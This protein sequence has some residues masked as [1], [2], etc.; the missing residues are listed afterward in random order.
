MLRKIYTV[1]MY[2][3][4]PL[5]VARLWWRSR[6]LPAY[7]Q[8]I[9]ER[10]AQFTSPTQSTSI[11]IHAV[12]LGEVIAAEP[13]IKA[14]LKQAP[15]QAIVVTTMT[16]TGSQRVQKSFGQDVFHVYVPYDVPYF[17]RRFMRACRPKQLIIMETELWPNLLYV[18]KQ[19]G[20][21]VVV[22]N[23]RLSARSARGYAK[24]RWLV[25][26]MLNNITTVAAQS[27]ADGQR[28]VALGL[29]ESRLQIMGNIKFD[30][31]IADDVITQGQTFRQRL[32]TQRPVWIAASTHRGED[33]IILA[34]HQQVLA[35]HPHAALL[36]VPRHPERFDE[37]ARLCNEQGFHSGRRSAEVNAEQQVI[38]GDSLGEMLMYYASADMAFVAG[39]LL[40]IGGHNVLEPAALTKPII[41]GPYMHNFQQIQSLLQDHDAVVTVHNA[42]ELAQQVCTW[43]DHPEQ[44][45]RCAVNAY[46]VVEENRGAL[47]RLVGILNKRSIEA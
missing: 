6:R 15:Q 31:T 2:L 39:S 7:R 20:L 33:E 47:G 43:I 44:G 1:L 10:F 28:F 37:V 42:D 14:L 13:L 21:P 9:G 32:G 35:Q 25:Q 26:G 4:L 29:P 34:A 19:T 46:G 17:I 30:I 18:A 5:I 16:P 27:D 8:R 11:W 40:P 38:V 12:S 36:I 22:A 24:I 41:T 45:K 23:A 3:A